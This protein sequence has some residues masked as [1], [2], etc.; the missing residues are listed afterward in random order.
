VSST[1]ETRDR[2][3]DAALAIVRGNR[4]TSL[5]MGEVATQAGLSRQ[6]VYLH[7]QDRAALLVAMARHADEARDISA[8]FAAIAKAPSARAAV[9]ALVALRAGDNP[10]AWPVERIFEA[11]RQGDTAVE[12]AWRERLA[13][14]LEACRAIA[15][16]FQGEGA[17]ARHLPPAA[18]ADL[19]WSLTSPRLWEELVIGRGWSAERYRSHVTY[20]AVGALTH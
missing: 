1:G 4:G 8:K 16:R 12:A 9:A 13:G 17:L 5:T 3:L 20:L 18:A 10:G 14:P 11:L 19:L 2:I 15:L 6:A 7:F